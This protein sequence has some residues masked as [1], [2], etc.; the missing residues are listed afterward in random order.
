MK[1]VKETKFYDL[2]GASPRSTESELKKAYR[3]LALK[4][5][6]D[7]NPNDPTALEKFKEISYAYEVLS[8]SK[9]RKLYDEGGEQA[10]KEGGPGGAPHSAFD[11]FDMFFGGGGSRHRQPSK[12]K[13][14]VHQLKVTLEDMYNGTTKRL[15]L[16][17]NVICEKCDG[18][19]GKE[20]AVSKCGSC[21]GTGIQVKIHQIGP[22]MMQQIQSMCREC[23]GKGERINAKDRCKNCNGK[24]VIKQSKILEVHVDKGMNEGQK[25]VFHGE[26]DQ[27][28]DLEAGD[29]I[30]VLVEKEHSVFHRQNE[31]LLLKMDLSITEALCGFQRVIK[32]LDSREIVVSTLPGEVIKYGDIKCVIGE[33]MP[34]YRDPFQKG[35]M[36][37]QFKVEFP[38]NH[39]TTAQ[40]IKKLERLLPPKDEVIMTDD[41]EE[42]GLQD[43]DPNHRSSA[44]GR[45]AY[46]EDDEDQPRGMQCQSH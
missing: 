26:G 32:T 42:V 19:G 24:K 33:G 23:D 30:I 31:D 7:K 13:D 45:N 37:V 10:L 4:C 21:R 2:L 9:K 22:G 27:E 18:R 3:K 11:I 1:M 12:G 35:R 15:S 46:D 40:N 20:G 16:Q 44:G 38:P 25:V 14:V 17:K 5:H 6:P 43:Y 41:M 8:D 39:W 29:V 34:I 36:I 28:P